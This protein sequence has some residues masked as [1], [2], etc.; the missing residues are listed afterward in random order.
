MKKYTLDFK[1]IKNKQS[2]ALAVMECLYDAVVTKDNK[3]KFFL[4]TEI[5]LLSSCSSV[6]SVT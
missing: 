4:R 5:R 6:L 3:N 1:Y 2:A